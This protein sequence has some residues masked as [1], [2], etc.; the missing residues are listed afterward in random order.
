VSGWAGE[1]TRRAVAAAGIALAAQGRR[2]LL[3]EVEGRQGVALR[4][5]ERDRL[6]S[7]VWLTH[8]ILWLA[9]GIGLGAWTHWTTSYAWYPTST[10]QRRASS[11]P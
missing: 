11:K 8:E 3:I 4:S 5:A 9:Q 7:L 6:A 1:A 2:T 10:P